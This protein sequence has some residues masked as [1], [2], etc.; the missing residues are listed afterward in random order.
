MMDRS[1][2]GHPWTRQLQDLF[3]PVYVEVISLARRAL[4]G[5][6]G[7]LARRAFG[8]CSGLWRM[9]AR[10]DC[11]GPWPGAHSVCILGSLVRRA[12]G[13]IAPV[14]GRQAGAR[15]RVKYQAS[16]FASARQVG[17]SCPSWG[18]QLRPSNV[19]GRDPVTCLCWL[20]CLTACLLACL[21]DGLPA[22]LL[23]DRVHACLHDCLPA[24]LASW[25]AG[26]LAAGC[27]AVW[28]PG[29]LAVWPIG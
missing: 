18:S 17:R 9:S 3:H 11:S 26:Q 29:C 6:L 13:G 4:G 23:R 22:G 27:L 7:C 10:W 1:P 25:P 19:G 8:R 21:L 15:W 14:S 28:L 2:T 16:D 24:C 20:A 12:L 5:M